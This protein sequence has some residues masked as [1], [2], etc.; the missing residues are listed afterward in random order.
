MTGPRPS[1]EEALAENERL[2][3]E[4]AASRARV[5]TLEEDLRA[6][7]RHETVARQAGGIAHDF[8]NVMAVIAGYADLLLRRADA[9]EPIRAHAASIKKATTWG[10]QLSRHVVASG[11]RFPPDVGAVDLNAITTGVARTLAPLFGDNIHV[12]LRLDPSLPP[13]AVQAGQ[14][15]QVVMNLLINARDAL[16]GGGRVIVETS[17]AGRDDGVSGIAAPAVRLRI[18]DTGCGMDATTRLRVFEPYFTTKG[19]GKGTGL[20][21]STVFGIVTQHGGHIDVGSEVGRG[22]TFTVYLPA[23]SE[24]NAAATVGIATP[25]AG[26]VLLVEGEPGVP[27]FVMEIL[28]LEGY[29]VLHARDATD[30]LRVSREHDGALSLVIA[31]GRAPGVRGERFMHELLHTRAGLKFVYLCG[32]LEDTTEDAAG[33]RGGPAFIRKPFTIEALM[34][35]ITDL[36]ATR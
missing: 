27:D 33:S 4:L 29:Q 30:A 32:D 14:L 9:S 25:P 7:Q 28:E 23:S 15:E 26:A 18:M 3:R 21:L 13:V 19:P 6:A 20:G 5:S 17:F 10:Q 22:A 34:R 36:L 31:D 8:S 1:V 12:V 11:R 35:T 16:A 24:T 2:H